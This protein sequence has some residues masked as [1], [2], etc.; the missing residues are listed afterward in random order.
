MPDPFIP[1]LDALAH[2]DA[3]QI[4]ATLP[5]PVT[6]GGPRN[7]EPLLYIC[8]SQ[9][10]HGTSPRAPQLT[11]AARL[12]LQRGANPD[13][14]SFPEEF[15]DN[16]LSCLYGAAGLNN[17]PDLARVLL[18]AGANP[19]DGESV[20]HSTEHPDLVCLK[21]LLHHGAAIQ[22][23]NALKHMLDRE[24]P[25]GVQLLLDHGADPN[26]TNL[27]LETALHW[28]VFRGRSPACITPL[29]DRGVNLNAR[30]NDG[31]TAYA[32]A[33]QMHQEETAALLASRGADTMVPDHSPDDHHLLADV[34]ANNDLRAVEKLLAAGIPI[35]ARG[36]LGATAL[37]WACW[38]GY[39]GM[40]QLLLSRGASLTAEDETY[41]GTPAGWYQHGLRSCHETGANFP[42]VE[43]LLRSAGA[44]FP[45]SPE[46]N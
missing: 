22:G 4:E 46:S 14:S 2:G 41:H 38:K 24:D 33:D 43:R 37:H 19:N 34:A 28:A 9:F 35:N 13:A 44:A 42:E 5:D 18:E 7:W 27:R 39:P 6:K 26:E 32:L 8:F 30:S 17:N 3:A 29:L 1:F 31:K 45:P 20:Y 15:P 40:V 21:L 25:E 10:A 11:Q 36:Q 12:L 16:P 23:T